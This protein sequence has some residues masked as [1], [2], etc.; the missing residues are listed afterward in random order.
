[1]HQLILQILPGLSIA[2]L[3]NQGPVVTLLVFAVIW[4]NQQHKASETANQAL[5]DKLE[6]YMA[7]DRCKMMQ[8][9]DNNTQMMQECKDLIK[10]FT[11]SHQ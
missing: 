6:A 2:N 9:I 3:I 10:Q 5:N 11:Q 4:F 1:M 7:D 8:I